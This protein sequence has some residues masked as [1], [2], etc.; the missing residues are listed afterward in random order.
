MSMRQGCFSLL[1]GLLVCFLAFPVFG[2]HST[3]SEKSKAK[4]A[5]EE[6]AKEASVPEPGKLPPIVVPS[7]EVPPAIDGVLEDATWKNSPLSLGEWLTYNPAYGEKL[8]QKTQVWL[9]HDKNYLY[10]AFRCLDPE[11]SKIKTSI[12]RRDTIWNDD[13]VGLSLDSLGSGQS[14]YDLFSNPNGIQG[15][16]LNSSTA[17][18]D[19]APDWVW[20]SAGKITPEG[21]N[22]EIRVPL[23]SLRFKSGAEVR[24]G[25]LFWRRI[26]RLGAS[27]SWP[28]LPR[29]QSIFTRYAPLLLGDVNRPLTLEAI[30]NITY[31]LGQTRVSPPGWGQTVSQPDAGITVKYGITSS[32]TLDGTYRPD[33]SQVE[34]DAFQVEINQRYP[35]F[36]GE[37]RPFF[38]EGMGTF[39]LAGTGGDG[40]MR[41]AMYTRRIVDPLYGVKLTG[42]PGKFAF[43]TLS[44]S[45]RAPGQVAPSDPNFGAR[46]NYNI[47]RTLYSIGKGSYVGALVTDTEFGGGHNRVVA[48]DISYH[49]GEHQR[50]STTVIASETLPEGGEPSRNGMAAQV[51]YSYG[52]KRYEAAGQ[53]EH[54]DRDFQM[55]TAFYNRTGIT[56]GW[57]YSG[58][59]LYP[60]AERYPWLKKITPMLYFR[61]Y[62]DRI[63]GGSDR[64]YVGGL[65]MSFTRQGTFGLNLVTG[66][67]PWAGQTFD[68]HAVEIFGGAQL[69]RW[70]NLQSHANLSRSIYYDPVNPFPGNE[71]YFS[72]SFTVQPNSRLN[73]TISFARDD[74]TRLSDGARVYA[75]NILNS[76]T[77]Y[78]IS[79]RFSARAIAQFDS[80]R[81]RLLTDFLGCYELVPGTVAYAG[82]GSLLERRS[83][84][85][86]QWLG[87]SGNYLN[88]Q[89]GLFFKVSYLYRF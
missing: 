26:S 57:A 40:N 58:I 47:A 4:K 83:W 14:S 5:K 49:L 35:I 80:S 27:A 78:Q 56:G 88:T 19:T 77:N 66:Q 53:L 73:Q 55:D 12:A 24:M 23:K 15:D 75:V 84:D 33:F 30:P 36:Y 10:L 44:A 29:G 9:A 71:K 22:V 46:K 13:W 8:A 85:G 52:S 11:P 76:R 70:L 43:A 3:K 67:E 59:N 69:F 17:G 61:G 37:K 42:S 7:V 82:Y 20:D 62:R 86:Q 34:S 48:S 25:V 6:P 64:I 63:Q 68:I 21:Y 41:T 60:D 2:Q 38:M 32:V 45:D 89:R 18:E 87:G 51:Y 54:Y 72:L 16:I 1:A 79:K 39:E 65:R 28:D 31:S 50:L 74:F 81:S